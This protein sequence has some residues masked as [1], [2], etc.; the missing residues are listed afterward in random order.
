VVRSGREISARDDG[1]YDSDLVADNFN[2]WSPEVAEGDN[3]G[4]T[5]AVEEVSRIRKGMNG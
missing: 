5:G 2:F 3:A 4:E 1:T